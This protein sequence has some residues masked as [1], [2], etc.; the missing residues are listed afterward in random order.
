MPSDY[1]TLS[2]VRTALKI[3]ISDTG[4]DAFLEAL[5]ER[6][7]RYIDEYTGRFFVAEAQTRYF[8]PVQDVY[9][10]T[11]L[12]D[13][14]LLTVTT[15]TNGDGTVVTASEYVFEPRNNSPKHGITLKASASQSWTF[16]TDP[17]NAISVEGTWGYSVTA[18]NP[19]TQA[20]IRL[21]VWWYKNRVQPFTVVGLPDAGMLPVAEN[22]PNDI[23]LLLEP[24]RKLYVWG[25]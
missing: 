11:L 10:R 12:L 16:D 1:T 8:D 20:C 3:A 18:P 6:A 7:S 24:Y 25:F 17:E 23:R 21:V 13:E 9:D 4:D 19:I 5:I 2:E 22:M 14:D 15:L